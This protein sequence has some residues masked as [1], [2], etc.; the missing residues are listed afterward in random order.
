V[1]VAGQLSGLKPIEHGSTCAF[2]PVK[3]KKHN[4]PTI[5]GSPLELV[6]CIG[7]VAATHLPSPETTT[8]NE[9][10]SPLK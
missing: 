10:E 9:G 7:S 4:F 6:P 8:T 5:S 3:L 1:N 2:D